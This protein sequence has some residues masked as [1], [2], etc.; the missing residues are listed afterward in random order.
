MTGHLASNYRI[1]LRG[2]R[3]GRFRLGTPELLF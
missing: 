3:G 2:M 1:Y